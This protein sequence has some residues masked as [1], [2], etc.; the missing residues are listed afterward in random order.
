MVVGGLGAALAVSA[1]AAPKPATP[2]PA[3]PPKIGIL[4]AGEA[5][6]LLSRPVEMD[7]AARKTLA[8]SASAYGKLQSL[9]SLSFDGSAVTVGVMQRPALY[10]YVQQT[11]DH[12]SIAEALCDG[13]S[14]YEYRE[15]T[16][17]YV[18]RPA[19][20]LERMPLPVNVR[21][22]FVHGRLDAVMAGL[23][24]RPGIR[25]YAFHGAGTA[26]VEGKPALAVKVSLMV[27]S[28]D[29][30]WRTFDSTRC[31]DPKSYLLV[32]TTNGD[33]KLRIK[34][35][36]NAKIPASEFRWIPPPGAVKGFG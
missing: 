22:F 23:D 27:R 29:G 4:R 16:K 10:H 15:T 11:T 14:Y 33:R 18:E 6:A 2:K 19:A 9:K 36:P 12:K 30:S 20:V 13:K 35:F 5:S 28:A 1:Q 25:E 3:P 24:G 32:E 31:F 26:K 8:R 17:Q 21:P 7:E 34:N